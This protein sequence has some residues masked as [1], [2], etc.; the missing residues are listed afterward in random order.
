MEVKADALPQ[1]G[2]TARA[3]QV[4]QGALLVARKIGPEQIRRHNVKKI[5]DAL[6]KTEPG[7]R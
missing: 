1:Q 3:H 2:Q 4:L 5:S 7:K 6:K